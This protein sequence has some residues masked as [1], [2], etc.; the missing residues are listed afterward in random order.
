MELLY[1]NVR[2]LNSKLRDIYLNSVGCEFGI[3]CLSESWLKPGV[4]DSEIFCQ[5][6]QVFRKD[7][8]GVK[9]GGGVLIAV[10][11]TLS[12]ELVSLSMSMDCEAEFICV[13]VRFGASSIIVTCSYIPPSSSVEVY[14]K[15]LR[16]MELAVSTMDGNSDVICVGDFNL[17][18]TSWVS[19]DDTNTYLPSTS[20][21]LM[22]DFWEGISDLGIHQINFIRNANNRILDLVFSSSQCISLCRTYP[23]V[24]PEDKHHPTLRLSVDTP[25]V[26]ISMP[27]NG[28]SSLKL[29]FARTNF[30]LLRSY[31]HNSLR[32]Y[33]GDLDL[34]VVNFYNIVNIGFSVSVPPQ[35]VQ[36]E[37]GPP[38]FTKELRGLRNV[39]NRLKR[40]Y[41]CG[42]SSVYLAKYIVARNKFNILNR[43]CYSSYISRMKGTLMNDPK[44]FFGFVNSKRK[45]V[46]FPARMSFNGS[47]SSN[48]A[49]IAYMFASFFRNTYSQSI[50]PPYYPYDISTV[51]GIPD[52][53]LSEEEVLVGLQTLRHSN[54]PGP[55]GVPSSIL[56][57][58]AN[59]LYIPLTRLFN[60]SLLSGNFPSIWKSSFIIPIFKS[61]NRCCIENYRGIAKLSAIPK[62]F[63][64]L[65]TNRLHHFVKSL[66][67]PYQH[68][69]IKG[70]SSTT[71]LLELTS[72]VFTAFREKCQ[73]DVIYT[74]LSKAFDTVVHELLLHKLNVIG[75]PPGLLYWIS[76]YLIGR[77]Q[78]VRFGDR[79]SSDITVTSGVPQ[80]SHLGPLLFVLYLNDL[81]AIVKSSKILMYADDVK[82]FTTVRV[83]EDSISLQDDLNRLAEWCLVNG[84]SLNLSKCKKLSFYRSSGL[85]IDYLISS[86]KLEDVSSFLDLGVLLD[87]RL[88]FDLHINSCINKARS[89]LGFI[90]RWSK[91]FDD[92]YLTKRLFVSLVRPCL[93][94]ACVVWCPHNFCYID[95]IESIQKQFLL[96]AL[97]GLAWDPQNLPPYKN[98]LMLIDLPTLERRRHMLNAMFI[99]KLIR[100]SVDST[101]LLSQIN[102]NVPRRTTRYFYPI[103][104]PTARYDYDFYN[105]FRRVCLIYN[106]VYNSL[107]ES[108]SLNII[109]QHL[110]SRII[111]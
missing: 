87:Q 1:Q 38:W 28:D 52:F 6:Y 13:R 12:A 10:H 107:P 51:N 24:N 3:I 21:S 62:L 81:P 102:F 31:L 26:D 89:L 45:V 48:G 22:D 43:K 59:E 93:E 99:I 46:G 95:R 8:L 55:D 74:D 33:D 86:H 73:V 25:V 64:K 36:S 97:R 18:L 40:K 76:S 50:S 68:G 60:D 19:V 72:Y 109:R 90:K 39:R 65:V 47:E 110:I 63:E 44:R 34:R 27:R 69:F 2:G 78:K 9:P 29:N 79:L 20:S 111:N 7:R 4:N 101:F 58:C 35:I 57:L 16:L 53:I 108:D 71:N 14:M 96:F 42:G 30:D 23:L 17:P 85:N 84:M 15:H 98:R 41:D 32:D 67:S 54:S 80:G 91:E 37:T 94:Y 88:R 56:R 77:T 5:D 66:V 49:D 103:N 92:P 106:E 105:P 70:R 61:G 104:L 11:C 100:G 82:L 75:F 83:S